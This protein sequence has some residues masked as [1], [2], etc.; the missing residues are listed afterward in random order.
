VR[1]ESHAACQRM[2]STR[3]HKQSSGLA[4]FYS[5]RA[6]T[7]STMAAGWAAQALTE[8]VASADVEEVA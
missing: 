2:E 5:S 4:R 6:V 1:V 3:G 7:C 8:E